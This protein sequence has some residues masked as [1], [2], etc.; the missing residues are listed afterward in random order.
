M[1]TYSMLSVHWSC[2]FSPLLLYAPNASHQM[3]SPRIQPL[4]GC[5]LG[6]A[7]NIRHIRAFLKV[8]S[9]T[10][11]MKAS[12][13]QSTMGIKSDHTQQYELHWKL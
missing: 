6:K 3:V 9:L 11:G 13:T 10:D 12:L 2:L 4:S 1:Q 7:A 8:L 5:T